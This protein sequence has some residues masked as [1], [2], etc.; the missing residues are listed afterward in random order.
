MIR[1]TIF[2]LS[3]T[4]GIAGAWAAPVSAQPTPDE[5]RAAQRAPLF[6]SS[7]P[8][9]IVI[10]TDLERLV[11]DREDDR[12]EQP[13]VV[14]VMPSD[15]P[16]QRL[17]VELRPRGNFRREKR[18]CDFPPV[19]LDF[20]RKKT[21]GTLFE[22]EDKLKLVVPCRK[23]RSSY[24]QYVLRELL[25]YR[26][27][28]ELHE[29]SFR[30]RPLEL[31]WIDAGEPADSLRVRAFVIEDDERLAQRLGGVRGDFEKLHPRAADPEYAMLV[32]LFQFMIGNTDWS[33]FAL[34]NTE[35]IRSDD[36]DY[37]TV[38]YDFDFSGLV[39]APYATPDPGF[40]IRDVRERLY[41][42]FCR[43]E[44][45]LESLIEHLNA[46]RPAVERRVREVVG[47]DD[48]ARE[49]VLRYLAESYDILNDPSKR[50]RQVVEACRRLPD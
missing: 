20:E 13:G 38:P 25:A 33:P 5:V 39:D 7:E 36:L 2:T 40:P 45:D 6:A 9:R 26:I 42:G 4:A 27:M 22:G 23:G 18:N 8:V 14:R 12:P 11:E 48:G 21:A 32:A 31:T 35:L 47:L 37:L 16:E 49:D 17:E 44:V 30:V 28:N 10:E 29:A 15:G 43:E 46:R 34:H 41:R 50:R 19:R 24:Q 1:H 3:L